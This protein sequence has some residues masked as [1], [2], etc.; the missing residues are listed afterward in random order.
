MRTI[1]Y[2]AYDA[3]YSPL[4]AL[5]LPLMAGYADGMHLDFLYSA[6]SMLPDSPDGIYW[7]KF[8]AASD[9]LRSGYDRFIWLDADIL[10]TNPNFDL[11]KYIGA[12]TGFHVPRDWGHD[13][14][15]DGDV[16]ACAV[17]VHQDCIPILE[18]ILALEPESRGNEFP[19]QTPMRQVLK[20]HRGNLG[21]VYY[22]SRKPFNCVPEE[23]CPGKVPEPWVKG[24]F[25]CHLTMLPIDKR[26]ELFHE[27][28][29]Q[30]GI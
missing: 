15:R 24:D 17:V 6:K 10:I 19:E 9:F 11:A 7:T 3:K 22:N 23:V 21:P 5:T 16:S 26:I 12:P 8:C 14:E 27:I 29:K 30:A 25:S 4:A 28:K 1:L 18:E 13:A 2:T 20:K